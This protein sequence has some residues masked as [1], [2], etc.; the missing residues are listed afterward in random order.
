ME[1]GIGP[2][3]PW[4]PP[5]PLNTTAH[6]R[7]LRA[8]GRGRVQRAR[9]PP[10]PHGPHYFFFS[11]LIIPRGPWRS[12]I[13]YT[14]ILSLGPLGGPRAPQWVQGDPMGGSKGPPG[15]PWGSYGIQPRD[16]WV[17]PRDPQV[18]PRNP[19]GVE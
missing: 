5:D 16:P 15:I 18:H 7:L 11:Y 8:A 9:G 12:K 2:M 4:G 19:W 6:G 10:G 3:G 1:K 13:L 14:S 17:P